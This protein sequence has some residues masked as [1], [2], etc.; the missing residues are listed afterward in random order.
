MN[1]RCLLALLA[2]LAAAPLAADEIPGFTWKGK[3]NFPG[4]AR[5]M[6]AGPDGHI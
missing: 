4:F 6:A 5:G 1:A 2:C 3:P